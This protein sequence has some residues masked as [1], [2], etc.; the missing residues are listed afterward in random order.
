MSELTKVYPLNA[1]L[2]TD[3]H[4][5]D[6][7]G[8]ET[9]EGVEVHPR[10]C[11]KCGAGMWDGHVIN[12]G[13]EYYC[14]PCMFSKYTEDERA[15]MYVRDE[16]YYTTWDESDLE[17]EGYEIVKEDSGRPTEYYLLKDGKPVQVS[18]DEYNQAKG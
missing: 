2:F 1:K 18:E 14:E 4:E 16:Q 9:K 13:D 12:D 5:Y 17:E 3:D 11:S 7:Y 10:K 15:E 6:V 8:Y